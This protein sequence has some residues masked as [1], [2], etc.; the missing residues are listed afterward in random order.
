MKMEQVHFRATHDFSEALEFNN[1]A[2]ARLPLVSEDVIDD[3]F[4]NLRNFLEKEGYKI[5]HGMEPH[6]D[7]AFIIDNTHRRVYPIAVLLKRVITAHL[8]ATIQRFVDQSQEVQVLLVNGCNS[9]GDEPHEQVPDFWI[10]LVPGGNGVGYVEA[11]EVL[12]LFAR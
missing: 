12:D 4:R 8:L 6:K 5:R 9:V 2:A 7:L 10:C 1:S 11:D 3:D